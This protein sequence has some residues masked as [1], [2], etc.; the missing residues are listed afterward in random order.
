MVERLSPK[1]GGK[2]SLKRNV[3]TVQAEEQ[4]IGFD[5]LLDFN[6]LQLKT[7]W[8]LDGFCFDWDWE[9][10]VRGLISYRL[11]IISKT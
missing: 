11:L 10:M 1:K 8:A 5:W 7:L 9:V 3:K 4:S 6:F 2:K